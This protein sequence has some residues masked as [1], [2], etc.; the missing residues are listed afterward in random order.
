LS[1]SSNSARRIARRADEQ[2]LHARPLLGRQRIG[3]DRKTVLGRLVDE[4]RLGAG[5]QGRAF[6][7]LVERV[8]AGDERAGLARIDDRLRKGEQRLARTIDRQHLVRGIDLVEA[9]ALQQP[10]GDRV[11]Q[12][13]AAERGR[14]GGQAFQVLDQRFLDEFGRRMLRLADRE[15]DRRKAGRRLGAFEELAQAFE[16]V[17]LKQVEMR[18]H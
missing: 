2:Q 16:G 6:V 4:S 7:D 13:L 10:V 5:Q 15:P 8:R 9:V 12:G 14:V 17:G 1:D 18:I 3:R 11:A